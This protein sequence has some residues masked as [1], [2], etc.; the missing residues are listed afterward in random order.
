MERQLLTAE[1]QLTKAQ[2]EEPVISFE[3]ARMA[4]LFSSTASVVKVALAPSPSSSSTFVE[5]RGQIH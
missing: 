2:R 3:R 4:D 5:C 1:Q